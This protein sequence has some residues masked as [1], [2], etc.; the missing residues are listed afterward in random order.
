M[1]SL[2]H[3][4]PG[5]I[6]STV[7][8][9]LSSSL[10]NIPC[11]P[12]LGPKRHRSLNR[13]FILIGVIVWGISQMALKIMMMKRCRAANY[14]DWSS[15]CSQH[16]PLPPCWMIMVPEVVTTVDR[17]DLHSQWCADPPERVCACVRSRAERGGRLVSITAPLAHCQRI[18][19]SEIS[20]EVQWSLIRQG[21][22][23]HTLFPLQ[24]VI[25]EGDNQNLGSC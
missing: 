10:S 6:L 8:V 18:L 23:S 21:R 12:F 15:L 7:T 22:E 11:G 16:G 17:I 20:G 4:V 9:H 3:T 1:R 13:Q 2:I 5:S 19:L 14:S 25:K 24:K